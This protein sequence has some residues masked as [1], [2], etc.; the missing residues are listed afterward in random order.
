MIIKDNLEFHA[1]ELRDMPGISGQQLV[2]IPAEI[3]DRLN[4]RGKFI[5]MDSATTEIR[6][7]TESPLVDITLSAIKP[8][9]GLDLLEVKVFYGNF[10]IPGVFLKPGMVTTFRLNPDGVAIRKIKSEYLRKGPGIGFAPNVIR[11]VPQR[12]GLIYCGINTFGAP[13]RPPEPSEKPSKTCLFYGSSITNSTADGFPSVVGKVLGVDV[14]N[15]GM[16]GSCHI[17]P[18]LSDWMAARNDWDLAVF[19]LGVNILWMEPEEF[20]RRA[21]YLLNAFLSRHPEKPLVLITLFP[22][23]FR[24]EMAMKPEGED[25]D[26][27]FCNILRELHAKYAGKGKVHLIEGKDILTDLNGLGADFLHPKLY[28]HALMGLNLAK[29]LAP[30]LNNPA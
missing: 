17:E 14:I 25:K 16:S 24:F 13:V 20:R 8:E 2:R 3:G 7:V 19:E 9:F 21:D 5:A 10:E 11:L 23:C 4:Q 30:L 15:L 6:F 12:G 26:G 29:Q 22:S 27:I 1:G 28:G 18:E